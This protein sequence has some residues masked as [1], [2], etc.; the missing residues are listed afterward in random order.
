MEIVRIIRKGPMLIPVKRDQLGA[1]LA[2]FE[3]SGQTAD[4]RVVFL[5]VKGGGRP[6]ATLIA[7]A[8]EG[9]GKHRFPALSRRELHIWRPFAREPEV[10]DMGSGRG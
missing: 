9:F 6:R 7:E 10:V 8:A 4:G 3:T 1:D 5:Q 2:Y